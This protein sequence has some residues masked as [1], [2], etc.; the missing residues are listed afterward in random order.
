MS[1]NFRFCYVI[2]FPKL[3]S[4]LNHVWHRKKNLAKRCETL[5]WDFLVCPPFQKVLRS[6]SMFIV[7]KYWIPSLVYRYNRFNVF[8]LCIVIFAQFNSNRRIHSSCYWHFSRW[9]VFSRWRTLK[10][11]V[12]CIFQFWRYNY[13]IVHYDMI[14]YLFWLLL[15]IFIYEPN[16]YITYY[17]VENAELNQTNKTNNLRIQY[18]LFE[19]TKET[20]NTR[21]GSTTSGAP[22]ITFSSPSGRYI[23]PF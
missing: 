16:L 18:P 20:G 15:I 23:P 13:S 9:W 6:Q 19:D 8:D 11:A 10:M 5:R 7:F 3:K 1:F 17:Y 22:L 4:C 14:I 12:S 21:N 2:A